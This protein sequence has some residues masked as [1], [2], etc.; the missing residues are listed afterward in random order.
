VLLSLNKTYVQPYT[1][2]FGQALL[3]VLLCAYVGAL[4]WMRQMTVGRAT[5]RFLPR[6]G[7][8]VPAR[9][10]VSAPPLPSAPRQRQA[11]P[12]GSS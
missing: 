3:T 6:M 8:S 11:S 2:G 12:S 7:G 1:S 9:D 4:V 5:P 10:P